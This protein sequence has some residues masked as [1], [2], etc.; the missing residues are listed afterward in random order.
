MV[1]SVVITVVTVMIILEVVF[2]NRINEC[3]E[4]INGELTIR[5]CVG[6]IKGI[7][8]SS[9]VF[10]IGFINGSEFFKGNTATVISIGHTKC[11]FWR[12]SF[13]IHSFH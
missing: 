5:V 11:H 4:F 7:L 3:S 1:V 13:V 9:H 10:F 2:V 8:H 12:G 6:R